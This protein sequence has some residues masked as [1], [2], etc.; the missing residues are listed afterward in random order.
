MFQGLYKLRD[1]VE[2]DDT[3]WR[4]VKLQ[5]LLLGSCGRRDKQESTGDGEL[6]VFFFFLLPVYVTVRPWMWKR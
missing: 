3:M 2:N 6:Y 4:V 5:C 1:H